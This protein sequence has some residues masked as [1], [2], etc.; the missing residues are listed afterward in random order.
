MQ[1]A[2]HM[3]RP[4]GSIWQGWLKTWNS[5]PARSE[6]QFIDWIARRFERKADMFRREAQLLAEACY[7][8]HCD[9]C[10]RFP[11]PHY[12]WDRNAALE[13]VHSEMEHWDE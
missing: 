4:I 9:S 3:I 13:I 5:V 12:H 7:R 2:S 8:Y 6:Q 10:A 11:H 1:L